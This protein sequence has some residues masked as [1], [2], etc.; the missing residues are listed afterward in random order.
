MALLCKHLERNI[1]FWLILVYKYFEEDH[2]TFE[3]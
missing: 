3:L 2:D 1:N